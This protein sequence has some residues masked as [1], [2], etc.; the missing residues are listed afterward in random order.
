MIHFTC[1]LLLETVIVFIYIINLNIVIFL[2]KVKLS[3]LQS[4]LLVFNDIYLIP[5]CN[6]GQS[7]TGFSSDERK[8]PWVKQLYKPYNDAENMQSCSSWS[9]LAKDIS[10]CDSV[11]VLGFLNGLFL[12]TTRSSCP[13]FSK[14]PDMRCLLSLSF[15]LTGSTCGALP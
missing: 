7:R 12:L 5:I 14:V 13:D 2:G 4:L 15:G 9:S 1:Y 3:V 8:R 6:P 10:G 11:Y